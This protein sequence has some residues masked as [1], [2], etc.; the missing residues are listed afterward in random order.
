MLLDPPPPVTNCHA[1]SDPSPSSVTYFMDGPLYAYYIYLNMG[2]IT[3]RSN[4]PSVGLMKVRYLIQA[5]LNCVKHG[6]P[7]MRVGMLFQ[8]IGPRHDKENLSFNEEGNVGYLE[9]Y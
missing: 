4:F 3:I 9:T 2:V 8:T 5:F 6:R 7:E 1:F